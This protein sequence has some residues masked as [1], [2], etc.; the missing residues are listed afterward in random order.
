MSRQ[1]DHE[2]MAE[3]AD[4][5]EPQMEA[6]FILIRSPWRSPKGMW[7]RRCG[8]RSPITACAR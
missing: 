6:R 4:A 3:A 5:L 2:A 1:T 7:T 8:R